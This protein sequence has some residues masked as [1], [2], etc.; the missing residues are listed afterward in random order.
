MS[1]IARLGY[2]GFEVS[3]VAAWQALATDVL[4]LEAGARTAA[5]A[6]LL[7]MDEL[8]RRI[9]RTRV[10]D[11]LA[12]AGWEVRDEPARAL[13]GR[14]GRRR[15]GMR[16]CDAAERGRDLLRWRTNGNAVGCS[17]DP[18]SRQARS[19]SRL[20]PVSSPASRLGH[21]VARRAA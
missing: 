12:H 3:G 16:R 5:G 17:S 13:A 7:R 1:E 15:R 11:D 6:L 14:L 20:C 18:A 9:S 4:G 8:E 2:L 21:F 19:P 10:R